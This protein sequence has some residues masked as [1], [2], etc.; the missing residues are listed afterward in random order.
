[1]VTN[2][3]HKVT[4]FSI[5]ASAQAMMH[6]SSTLYTYKIKAVIRE[7]CCNA[8]DAHVAAGKKDVPFE[9]TL[10]SVNNLEFQVK[11]FGTGMSDKDVET[12]Y[13]TYF[14]STKTDSNDFTGALGLGSK[15]PFCYTDQFTIESRFNGHKSIYTAFY[16]ED[17]MPSLTKLT[18]FK[19]D[20]E[21]GMTTEEMKEY[22]D[23]NK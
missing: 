10:P 3:N 5:K 23:S 20:E 12:L 19:T 14:E 21:N 8:F 18:S 9:V 7:I 22:L 11:D 4:T 2:T 13:T 1:M 6:L 17:Y 15:S 16:D